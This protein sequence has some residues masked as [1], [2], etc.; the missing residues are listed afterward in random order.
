[1]QPSGFSSFSAP[2]ILRPIGTA[3]LAAGLFLLGA[4]AY[5]NLPVASLPTVDFPTLRVQASRPGADPETMAATIAAPLER[6][7]GEI[8]GVTELTSVSSQ[9]T[10]RHLHPV[11]LEPQHRRRR[12]RRAGGPKCRYRRSAERPAAGTDVPQAQSLRRTGADP[13]DDLEDPCPDRAL[14]RRRHCHRPAH[15][16][17]RRRGAGA[18]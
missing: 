14:R 2:F 6:R 9:G 13:C 8:A 11:R 16:A 1:M 10:D 17:G 5:V 18:R 12:P 4:V 15:V 3:L 7:L